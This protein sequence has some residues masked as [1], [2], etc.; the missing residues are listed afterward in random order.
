MPDGTIPLLIALFVLLLLSGFFSATETAYSCV[1][2][3]KLKSLI[4]NGNKRAAKTLK[5]AENYD[6]LIST[7]LVGNNIV[8]ITM[9]SIATLF[10]AALI[11]GDVSVTVSTVVTTVAV[12]I[13]GEITPKFIAKTYP[14]KIAMLYYPLIIFFT[15]ILYPINL[16]FTGY[17]K[18]I[19]KIFRLKNNEVITEEELMTM[20]EEAEEDGTLR[21]DETDLIRSVIEFDDLEVGDILIPRVNITAA[22]VDT[23][24]DKI[25][26]LFD[27]EG[28][29]RIPVYKNTIDTVIGILH[30]KDFFLAYLGGKKDL[31]K[32]LQDVI[33]T[34]EH[35]KISSLL[36]QLQKKKTHMA[37]VL[38]EYGGTLGIVTL[39]DILEEL[40]GEI[41]DE[42]DEEVNFFKQVDENTT[43]VDAKAPLS[44]MFEYFN[45]DNEEFE[46][47]TVSGWIIEKL[48]EIPAVGKKF[49]FMRLNI[50]VLKSTVKRVLEI[51]VTTETP[52][53]EEKPEKERLDKKLLKH[54]KNNN[55]EA[56]ER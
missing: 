11:K 21:Q 45:I 50:E 26:Q 43:I 14:E 33:Y 25:K 1:N 41:W 55:E 44:D 38:D 51:R 13:F 56:E 7:V 2:K 31:S 22:S 32:I 16:I 37:I 36:K 48:G 28:Y 34:T 12:L 23:P 53:P 17:K 3:I 15:Y 35:I 27:D 10:F 18:L 24:F 47:N 8:N 20:V 5:L 49:E 46:A 9:A 30:E 52:T 6:K 42:H 40:V 19:S 4:T 29:S 54:I 39:E